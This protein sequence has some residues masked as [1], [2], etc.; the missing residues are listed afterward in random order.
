MVGVS[1]L[2]AFAVFACTFH[3][4]WRQMEAPFLILGR[5]FWLIS[6]LDLFSVLS[7]QY[8]L[9]YWLVARL[10]F[11]ATFLVLMLRSSVKKP[12]KAPLLA[13][14]V[15][16]VAFIYYRHNLALAFLISSI[17]NALAHTLIAGTMSSAVIVAAQ[18]EISD[19]HEQT[20]Q[21]NQLSTL[22]FFCSRLGHD[23]RNP[24]TVI[25][26]N[27]QLGQMRT[28]NTPIAN[29]FDRIIVQTDMATE[30]VN[31]KSLINCLCQDDTSIFDV[32]ELVVATVN[33]WAPEANARLLKLDVSLNNEPVLV[34][35]HRVLLQQALQNLL[36]NAMQASKAN[37]QIKLSV[38]S[39][40]T[41]AKIGV[42]NTGV[43]ISGAVQANMFSEF[44]ADNQQTTDLGLSVSKWLVDNEGGRIWF[45]SQPGQGSS[46]YIALPLDILSRAY[47]N[48]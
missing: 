40:H 26:A 39:T 48:A 15:G 25:R 3:P 28:A 29:L 38:E 41:E 7:S 22:A 14:V 11:V 4:P 31:T 19:L 8:S 21:G 1:G 33:M 5:S 47:T 18:K 37:T 13:V 24:L 6:I 34:K 17:F 20:H 23:I 2:A 10:W 32:N 9:W 45:T 12:P 42:H 27:A 30:M 35:A 43:G 16:I 46:F 44:F 36:L